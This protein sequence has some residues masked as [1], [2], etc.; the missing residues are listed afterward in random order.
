MKLLLLRLF[1][2]TVSILLVDFVW[3]YVLLGQR[4]TRM[5]EAIQKARPRYERKW[6][7][8]SAQAL[9]A[10]GLTLLCLKEDEW[11]A[12]MQASCFLY[13]LCAFGIYN[14]TNLFAFD[15]YQPSMA[16]VDTLYG[17]L[18][19]GAVGFGVAKVLTS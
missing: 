10:A 2:V 16:A 7:G 8:L 5:F 13:G 18:T 15:D 4:Y 6:A 11:S 3:L 19:C 1:L 17:T 9:V 12:E 14:G